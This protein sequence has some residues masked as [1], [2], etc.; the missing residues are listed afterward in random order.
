MVAVLEK[1]RIISRVDAS[2]FVVNGSNLWG[3]VRNFNT[4]FLSLLV[5]ICV[6]KCMRGVRPTGP[7]CLIGSRN[8]YGHLSSSV[9]VCSCEGERASRKGERERMPMGAPTCRE[10]HRDS[11]AFV[12]QEDALY[13]AVPL[14]PLT[15]Q[16]LRWWCLG[17]LVLAKVL[18]AIW[19]PARTFL[20][21]V[22]WLQIDVAWWHLDLL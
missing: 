3:I 1:D 15:S 4:V 14:L 21:Q 17:W 11:A 6:L 12:P 10:A 16:Q 22:P 13:T 2:R 7:A 9:F 18:L 5:F 8:F 20:I 19:L